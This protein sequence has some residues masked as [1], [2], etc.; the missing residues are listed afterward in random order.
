MYRYVY[1]YNNNL[2]PKKIKIL[3][4]SEGKVSNNC[5]VTA[6]KTYLKHTSDSKEG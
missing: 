5:P 2:E 6:L 1:I 4:T 3:K